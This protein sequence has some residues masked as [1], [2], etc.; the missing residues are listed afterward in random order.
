MNAPIRLIP[1]AILCVTLAGCSRKQDEGSSKQGEDQKQSASQQGDG[2]SGADDKKAASADSVKIQAADQQKA[3]IAIAPVEVASMPQL[4]TLNGQVVPNDQRTSHVGVVA[5]GRITSL[6]VLPGAVVRRGQTLGQVHSH[7]VHETVG[8]LLQAFAA[9]DRAKGAVTFATQARDRYAKLYSIQA[10]SL[11]EKQ[12]SE[13]DLLQ[14]KQ[15]LLDADAS[16]H[17]EREHLSELLQVT[18]ESLNANNLYNRELV[19]IRSPIDGVVLSRSLTVGQVVDTGTEA[20]LVSDLSTVWVTASAN[21]KDISLL[22]NGASADVTTQGFPD[23]AFNGR[24][25]NVGSELDP[26]TRTI[27]V[28]I[29]I[30]NP[31]QRLRPGMFAAAHIAGTASRTAVFIPEDALQNINGNQVVFLTMDGVTF[32]PQIVRLG[33]HSKGRAEI[34]QGLKPGD[35]IVVKGAFMVKGELLKGTVGDG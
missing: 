9:V 13:Q 23:L 20:F 12:K 29:V 8:A 22:H 14:A 19:P 5:D 1:I 34:V 17:M 6:S 27:P 32:R 10:A 15:S 25:G 18:P 3:G 24:V 4:L 16:V 21:E 26:Q 31:G 30:P 33:T 7:S 28:R 2:K 11:E 35:H